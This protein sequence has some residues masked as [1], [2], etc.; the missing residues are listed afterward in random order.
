MEKVIQTKSRSKHHFMD[1]SARRC[2]NHLVSIG[3]VR[4]IVA[5]CCGKPGNRMRPEA[6]A[7]FDKADEVTFIFV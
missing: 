6:I 4:A 1:S 5:K 2:Q 7:R 3:N